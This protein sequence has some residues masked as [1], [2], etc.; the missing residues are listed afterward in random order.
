MMKRAL[1]VLVSTFSVLRLPAAN[2]TVSV[3]EDCVIQPQPAREAIGR[4]VSATVMIDLAAAKAE[5]LTNVAGIAVR[6]MEEAMDLLNKR[7][8]FAIMSFTATGVKDAVKTGEVPDEG[9]IRIVGCAY[10]DRTDPDNVLATLT[11]QYAL[12]KFTEPKCIG[13]ANIQ[14]TNVWDQIAMTEP[15]QIEWGTNVAY[16]A[17][18]SIPKSMAD[19]KFFL[20]IS[21]KPDAPIDDG[22]VFDIFSDGTDYTVDFE[23]SRKYRMRII[24]GRITNLILVE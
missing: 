5:V 17:T 19:G 22:Q 4:A 10:D 18:A 11:W 13:T 8:D 23:P 24:S 1:I 14:T 16:R 2:V 3:D 15:V 20:R 12:G 21:A 6:T 7:G 9:E